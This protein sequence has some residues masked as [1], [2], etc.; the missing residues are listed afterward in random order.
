M[1]RQVVFVA[2][3]LI[4]FEASARPAVLDPPCAVQTVYAGALLERLC[5][6]VSYGAHPCQRLDAYIVDSPHPTPVLIALHGGSFFSGSKSGFGSYLD[7]GGG[8]GVI[9][10]ALR[11][12]ISVISVGYRLSSVTDADCQPILVGGT[13]VYAPAHKFPAPHEDA[14]AALA[15][16]RA[17]ASSGAWNID[18]DR[19]AAIGTSAG[20]TL[21]LGL[22][23]RDPGPLHFAR[24]PGATPP[25][26]RAVLALLAP[27]DFRPSAFDL[28]PGG[29]R[30]GW[31]FGATD[32]QQF[33]TDPEVLARRAAA[34]P[35]AW[36]QGRTRSSVDDVLG[37]YLGNPLWGIGDVDQS[38]IPCSGITGPL[39]LPTGNPHAAA[40]GLLLEDSLAGFGW[41][42]PRTLLL[43]P[44]SCATIG[45]ASATE[46]ADF[47]AGAL[48]LRPGHD[49]RI[50]GAALPLGT[51]RPALSVFGRFEP[52]SRVTLWVRDAPVGA[53]ARLHLSPRAVFAPHPGGTLV[54]G[55]SQSAILDLSP[56][57][58][59]GFLSVALDPA[60]LAAGPLFA[61]VELI[62][63][64]PPDVR[65]LTQAWWLE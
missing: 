12:G 2:A 60:L 45:F 47:L 25:P 42:R 15:L 37:V 33:R 32:L 1:I 62:E 49:L 9:E 46:S 38:G 57:D 19:I 59:C 20:G 36:I 14:A 63:P 7:G 50:G 23:F 52:G 4:A 40:F 5:L 56:V 61:Q 41:K 39:A 28:C 43:D 21:A 65:T 3:T 64:G 54:P 34:S 51:P 30:R 8:N 13:E 16:V 22:A 11:H 31:H 26:L 6:D 17:R 29:E 44:N 35:L 27:T 48:G 55:G 24:A 18:A 10:L 53:A 58:D